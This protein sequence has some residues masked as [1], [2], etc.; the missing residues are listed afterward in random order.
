MCLFATMVAS[1]SVKAQ[2][3]TITLMPG[4]TWISVP[5]T[6]VQD[7]ATT[8]GSFTPMTGDIIKSQWGNAT[9]A[10]GQWRGNI[11]QFYPGYG[12]MYKSTRMMPVTVTFNAQQ[13]VPQIIVTTAEPTDITAISAVVGGTVTTVDGN[14]VSMQSGIC[15]GLNPNPTFNDNYIEVENGIGNFSVSMDDLNLS[16]TYYFRAY[17]VTSNGTMFG[18]QKSF[19]TRNGIPTLTTTVVSNIMGESA[20]GGG[21]ITDDGGLNITA[22]GIC[23]SLSH[24]PTIIDNH[25]TDGT[26]VGVFTSGIINLTLNTTYYVRAYG[27]NALGT[28]YG[29]ELSF[30]TRNGI[31]E[32]TTADVTN[33]GNWWAVSGGDITDDGGLYITE[34][35]ICWSTSSNPTTSDSHSNNGMDTGSYMVRMVI[36]DPNTT[37]YVRAYAINSAGTTYGEEKAFTTSVTWIDGVLPGS[38]SV[39]DSLQV[40]FSQGNLQYIPNASNNWKFSDYQWN[41]IGSQGGTSSNINRDLFAW[42]T[43]GYYTGSN[44]FWPSGTS[45]NN[46]D[47][48]VYGSYTYNLYD[49]TG[50]ADWGYNPISN[51]G[52]QENQ[53]RTLTFEEWRYVLQYR[54]TISGIRYAKAQVNGINGVILLPDNWNAN[55]YNLNNPNENTSFSS[56]MLSASQWSILEEVGAVFL[57]AAGYRHGTTVFEVGSQGAYWSSSSCGNGFVY[58]VG[59]DTTIGPNV[60]SSARH[61]GKSVRLVKDF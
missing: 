36:L 42:G 49:Q 25:S 50:M 6:E 20:I 58:S 48:Y 53:W 27:I 13:T 21:N 10:N 5:I 19:T 30:T 39:S 1:L 33:I 51:G 8:L 22:R 40:H 32:L 61:Y 28:F 14:Y 56:N 34:R 52:N 35:G 12:Y 59:F 46:N 16:T 43:S 55:I 60:G 26:G 54:N 15:W 44:C 4:W 23:W 45:T 7:F 2:E 57:P 38:F 9:Y 29:N 31:P 3:V 17:A 18:E 24:N 37:Y 47:Y 41:Y 11:S